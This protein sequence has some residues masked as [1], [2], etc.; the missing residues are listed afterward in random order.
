[1]ADVR[2][3]PP[4]DL[5][6]SFGLLK[7]AARGDIAAQRDLADRS[8]L[9]A[10]SRSDLNPLSVL[11]DGLIFARL[12]ASQGDARDDRRVISMLA[13]M[14][15]LCDQLGDADNGEVFAAEYIARISLLADQGG[16]LADM[17][18][19]KAANNATPAIMTLALDYE[20]AIRAGGG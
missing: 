2:D 10:Q 12:A 16:E 9:L 6:T 15:D 14:G 8:V 17:A 7:G 18:L 11:S 13:L 20:R 4:S 3:A 5:E 19:G 1:M